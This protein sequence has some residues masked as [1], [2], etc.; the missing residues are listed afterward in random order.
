MD[1]IARRSVLRVGLV[2]LVVSLAF[3]RVARA[4]PPSPDLMARLA[5][6]AAG[7]EA[8][9]TRASY[10]V[11][12]K[13][14]RI[15]GDGNADSVREM[16]AQ[17]DADGGE[18]HVRIVKY[19]EDGRDKTD[20]ARKK[21]RDD[22]DDD[23]RDLKMPFLRGEQPRYTFD[24]IEADRADPARVRIAFV[25][26]ARADDTI[27]GSAWVDTRTGTVLSAGF[28]LSKTPMFVDY[29][30]ITL[31]FGAPT[32]LGPAVSKVQMVGRGGL[33]FLRKRFRAAATLSDYRVSPAAGAH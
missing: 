8:M 31:E 23:D 1:A 11:D 17:V 19:V 2:V 28:K 25:P 16:Q 14:E 9:K 22:K 18:V 10:A 7:F 20:E 24:Q 29:V 32:S 15:D 12:G 5:V 3:P 6:H 26:R 21:A 30:H 4:Q 33:L 13:L 27:E